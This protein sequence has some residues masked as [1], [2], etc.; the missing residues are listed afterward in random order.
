MTYLSNLGGARIGLGDDSAAETDLR[1]VIEM[2]GATRF[3]A[4][5][6]TYYFLAEALLGQGKT[7]EALEA[8]QHALVL[9]QETGNPE[10]IGGAWRT[11]GLVAAHLND[12]ITIDTKAL[13]TGACFAESL[14]VWT[15]TGMEAE[16]A[17][18][19]R[20]WARY[21]Q[22]RGMREHGHA[23]MKEAREIFTRLGM[24][25]EVERMAQAAVE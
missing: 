14:R 3:Y 19:L 23:M 8:A 22:E 17:R 2:A 24:E 25:L 13:D 5:S 18:T 7:V 12:S 10:Y 20:A 15:E 11:L 6:E 16:R 1:H 4:L 21:E 9:G